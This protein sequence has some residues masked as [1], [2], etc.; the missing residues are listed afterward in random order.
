MVS[1]STTAIESF[2][3]DNGDSAVVM[4]NLIRFS[5]DG[6]RSRYLQYLKMAQ[7]ILERFGA[8][9]LFKGDG[10]AVLTI[11]DAAGWDAVVLVQ[12]PSRSAFKNMVADAEYQEAFKVGVSAISDIVLQPLTA[13]DASK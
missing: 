13:I 8:H 3:S 9:I 2:L 5:P 10:L 11:D 6:G 7:P 12:Y 1:L 4:L